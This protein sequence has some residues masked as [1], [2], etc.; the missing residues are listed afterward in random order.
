MS[1]FIVG[2][3]ACL[4]KFYWKG[5]T[6][7]DRKELTDLNEGENMEGAGGHPCIV[8][9]TNGKYAL[10]TTVSAHGSSEKNRWRAPWLRRGCQHPDRYRS[11]AGTQRFNRNR[12]FLRLKRGTWPKPKGSW[13]DVERVLLV[14]T[15]F[16]ISF[17]KDGQPRYP[18]PPIPQVADESLDDLLRQIIDDNYKWS[19][20]LKEFEAL[21]GSKPLPPRASP[22][23]PP[24]QLPPSPPPTPPP[25]PAPAKASPPSPAGKKLSWADVAAK[26]KGR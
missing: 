5:R 17:V 12:A 7:A 15:W 14:P 19:G 8:L 23:L 6:N 25:T 3:V 1:H 22:V 20:L 26:G 13:V 4:G 9:R 18:P 16:L 10:V 2:D 24:P 21:G 11:F